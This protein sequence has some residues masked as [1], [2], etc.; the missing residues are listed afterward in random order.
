MEESEFQ[1][2][3]RLL[4]NGGFKQNP[5]RLEYEQKV[6]ELKSLAQTLAEEGKTTEEIARELHGRRRALGKRYKDAVPPLL[7]EYIYYA[8]AKKYGDPL[9]PSYETLRQRKTPEQI[10]ESSQRPIGNLDERLTV[11]G[12]VEWYHQVRQKRK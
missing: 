12:F 10:I 6:H 9:G 4:Q 1:K 5:L 2:D 11:E 7:T 3:L 8:T